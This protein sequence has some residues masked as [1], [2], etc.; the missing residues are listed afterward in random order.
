MDG[1]FC[2]NSRLD[3]RRQRVICDDSL[4]LRAQWDEEGLVVLFR[5]MQKISSLSC[6]SLGYYNRLDNQKTDW[7][8]SKIDILSHGSKMV[9]ADCFEERFC[10]ETVSMEWLASKLDCRRHWSKDTYWRHWCGYVEPSPYTIRFKMLLRLDESGIV[11]SPLE[12]T[13]NHQRRR[14][15]TTMMFPMGKKH[16]K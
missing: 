15:E 14:L 4:T 13:Q 9:M 1:L 11:W 3:D 8:Y 6:R 5:H 16:M 12:S 2:A 10:V 7:Y